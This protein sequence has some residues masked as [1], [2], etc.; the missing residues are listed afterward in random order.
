MFRQIKNRGLVILFCCL[1]ASAFSQHFQQADSILQL[2]NTSSS[3]SE[4]V[5]LYRKLSD[6]YRS[7]NA[8][9]QLFYANKMIYHAGQI[10]DKAGELKGKLRRV[11]AIFQ[12][13]DIKYAFAESAKLIKEAEVFNDTMITAEIYNQ[14]GTFYRQTN[15]Y[16]KAMELFHRSL[17]LYNE[18][19][20]QF[21]AA[22]VYNNIA[23]IYSAQRDQK[24]ALE[25]FENSL[26]IY[27]NQHDKLNYAKLLIN[28]AIIYN[29]I[30]QHQ[31]ALTNAYQGLE[32]WQEVNNI[33][34]IGETYSCLADIFK[35]TGEAKLQF[36]FLNK[37]LKIRSSTGNK[38][39]EAQS[40][41]NLANFYFNDKQYD[42]A[43][44]M[45]K[46][47]VEMAHDLALL[48]TLQDGYYLLAEIKYLKADYKSAFDNYK[49]YT[50][51]KDSLASSS[52]LKT[53][54]MYKSQIESEKQE[55]DLELANM[56]LANSQLVIQK[57]KN[58]IYFISLTAILLLIIV[59]FII[60]QQ[61]KTKRLNIA[62][63]LTNKIVEE[64]NK[65]ILDSIT[66][67][68]RIQE[69]ILPSERK[70]QTLL[71]DSFVQYFPK[72]IVAGDF[73]WL[74]ETDEYIF[75][76]AADCTG[77]G[78]PGAMVSVICSNAL[79]K[80]VLEE[81]IYHTDQILNRTN[82]LVIE[83]LSYASATIQDGMDICL[84]RL[85]K[86]NRNDLQYSGAN[87]PLFIIKDKDEIVEIKPTK[88]PI[89]QYENA[90]PFIRHELTSKQGDCLFLFTDGITDQFG[91]D[92]GKKIGKRKFVDFLQSNTK[93]S[94]P[95]QGILL[96]NYFQTWKKSVEQVDDV[97]VI[98]IRI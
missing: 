43:E 97:C 76:A 32:Y 22:G 61:R 39:G 45:A 67:A 36:E 15:N 18:K 62:L 27:K 7:T 84:I 1:T 63:S 54:E 51:F 68:K 29:H 5:I 65:D 55:K 2:A 40:Y 13:G 81:N 17:Q 71:P 9:K 11:S 24:K 44:G 37:A 58:N 49:Q 98:G 19:N 59:G 14:V 57:Q 75:V 41:A 79:T 35:S 46:K 47:A 33:A 30:G 94:M 34:A 96:T 88:Q 38:R 23:I 52:N 86:I 20:I 73:Y 85:S 21:E 50:L 89:G 82:E 42:M 95:D 87:R 91:G 53:I 78:V 6:I 56:K 90:I 93:V 4:K 92:K 31:K 60:M 64:K 69:A 48:E 12:S 66:Y 72:D 25:Y 28:T 83:K 26:E 80:A 8:E 10:D 70:W 74:E 77:H 16:T 3:D